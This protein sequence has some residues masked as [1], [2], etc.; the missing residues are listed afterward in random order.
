MRNSKGQY[1]TLLCKS[2]AFEIKFIFNNYHQHYVKYLHRRLN[3][4]LGKGFFDFQEGKTA[5][6]RR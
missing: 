1:F 4:V 6:S 2:C 5:T 3:C